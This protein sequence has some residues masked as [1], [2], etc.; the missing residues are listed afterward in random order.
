MQKLTVLSPRY[1][2]SHEAGLIA[3]RMLEP[4]Y[5]KMGLR[6]VPENITV[7]R[8]V[9]YRKASGVVAYNN[10]KAGLVRQVI[11]DYWLQQNHGAPLFVTGE[12]FLPVR[13]HLHAR[14]II[15]SVQEIDLLV[16]HKHAFPQVEKTLKELKLRIRHMEVT[17]TAEAAR[18]VAHDDAFRKAAAIASADAGHAYGLQTLCEDMQDD[19]NNKTFFHV[20]GSEAAP[21]TNDDKTALIFSL[22][23]RRDAANTAHLV[24]D[25]VTTDENDPPFVRLISHGEAPMCAFYCEFGGHRDDESGRR[26]FNNLRKEGTIVAHL[27]SF[28]RPKAA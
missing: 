22:A 20:L 24:C 9:S 17:S 10:S 19:P 21:P 18:L 4:V 11:N 14:R 7:L 8:D 3:M 26:I 6:F 28:P 23:K 16:S 25:L 12:I 2:F 13:L 27:G 15:K 1:T 5:G